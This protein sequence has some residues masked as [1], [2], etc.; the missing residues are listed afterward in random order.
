MPDLSIAYNPVE[1]ATAA[2]REAAVKRVEVYK[3]YDIF[4]GGK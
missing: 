2:A 3:V 4:V 1:V